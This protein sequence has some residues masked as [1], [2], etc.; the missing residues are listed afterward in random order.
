MDDRTGPIDKGDLNLVGKT[1]IKAHMFWLGDGSLPSSD[2]IFATTWQTA[3]AVQAADI[4]SEKIYFVQ[5]FEPAFYA[6]GGIHYLAETTY[7][8]GFYGITAGKWLAHTLK[9]EYS[10][11]AESFDFGIEPAVYRY[12]NPDMR[13]EILFYSRYKTAR[14]GFEIGILALQLFHERHPEVVINLVGS[15]A[16]PYPIPFPYI[17][18]KRLDLSDLNVLYNKC[19][20]ALVLSFTN[21]SL[22]PLELLGAGTIPVVNKGPNNEMVSDNPFIE[23]SSADPEALAATIEKTLKR[24]DRASYAKKAAESVASSTWKDSGKDFVG[25][26]ERRMRRGQ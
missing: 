4:P 24:T 26:F 16:S 17:N 23:Y 9:S 14:R 5:D 13:N 19:F 8:F 25:I 7:R 18:H 12:D 2:A 22:L 1:D 6:A 21:F 10:M 3:Y 11:N 15:D 20:A